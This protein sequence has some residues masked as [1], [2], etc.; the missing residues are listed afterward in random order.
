MTE[1]FNLCKLPGRSFANWEGVGVMVVG[2]ISGAKRISSYKL[3][4]KHLIRRILEVCYLLVKY[5]S[6][7]GCPFQAV[8]FQL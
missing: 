3:Y 6:L 1:L 4:R 2:G 7:K 5:L 8:N